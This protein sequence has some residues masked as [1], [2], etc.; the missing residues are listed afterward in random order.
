MSYGD[1]EGEA[2]TGE[3]IRKFWE[4]TRTAL[5][6]V[7]LEA[8]LE[9]VAQSDVFSMEG[10]TKTRSIDRVIMSSFEARCIRAW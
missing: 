9:P 3:E 7:K 4:R 10:R 5:A 1:K 8:T 6:E 2:M